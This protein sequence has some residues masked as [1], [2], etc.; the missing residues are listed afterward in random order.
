MLADFKKNQSWQFSVVEASA[1]SGKTYALAKRFLQLLINE[2][3]PSPDYLR[4]VLAITFTNKAAYEMKERILEILKNIALD[5]F[6][7]KDQK[8]DI[9]NSLGVKYDFARKQAYLLIEEIIHHYSY[10]SVK[11][12]DS[13]INS[14]LLGCS[15]HISRS[16]A[17]KIKRNYKDYL[18]YALDTLIDKSLL[19][20]DLRKELNDFL[21]HYLF[22]ENRGS[23]FPK[24]KILDL[25]V[26][27]FELV[28][29][30]GREFSKY[31][32]NTD[33]L[34]SKKR[35]LYKKIKELIEVFPSSFNK[36]SKNSF[37]KFIEKDNPQF[38]IA[39][40]PNSLASPNP[41]LNKGGSVD[42]DFLQKWYSIYKQIP[43]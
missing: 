36:R 32:A 42:K 9:I 38:E 24:D 20:Q 35:H 2:T 25:M 29:R 31:K 21:R 16:A 41:P 11:T 30:Y 13:F 28:N 4:T 14:L 27:L 1:G 5:S 33:L 12:I 8:E 19:D 26:A 3:N 22:V 40:L 15:L 34:L 6:S 39:N 18:L 37:L 17:F 43:E 7:S 10:F 23:W